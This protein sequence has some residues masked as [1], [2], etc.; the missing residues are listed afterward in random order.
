MLSVF[1]DIKTLT[2]AA[3]ELVVESA[4]EAVERRGRCLLA[5]SG[6]HSPKSLYIT[7]AQEPYRDEMPWENTIVLWSDERYVPLSDERSNAG[8]AM[9][10]LLKHVSVHE[11]HIIVMYKDG[12]SPEQAALE[13]ERKLKELFGGGQ[14]RLDLT[15]LG[16]GPDAHTASLFPGSKAIDEQKALI[17][18]VNHT[19]SDVPRIT[20]TPV[21]INQSR[22]VVFIAYGQEKAIALREVLTGAHRPKELPAQIVKPP[23]GEV[24]WYID[25]PAASQLEI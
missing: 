8:A 5:L 18:A 1:P 6:G 14:P 22:T 2:E 4:Q 16:C 15:L 24:L 13:Y 9:E 25:G 11:N 17:L 20:M 10:L 21:L 19:G 7:L 23:D 12:L 3:A